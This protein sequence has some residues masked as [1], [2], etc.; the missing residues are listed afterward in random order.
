MV[1]ITHVNVL[2]NDVNEMIGKPMEYIDY[3]NNNFQNPDGK[4]I[5]L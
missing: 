2:S 4:T 5:L 1:V 3:K